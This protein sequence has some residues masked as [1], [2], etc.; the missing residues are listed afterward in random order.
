[1]QIKIVELS[2]YALDWAVA[3]CLRPELNL[4]HIETSLWSPSTNWSQGGRL[5]EREKIS[6]LPPK[7]YKIGIERHDFP[8]TYWRSMKQVGDQIFHGMGDTPLIAAMRCYVASM[9]CDEH[10]DIPD[11]LC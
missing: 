7:V 8:V 4:E 2:G 1:M 9:V 3:K 6:V 5:V 11:H 10:V